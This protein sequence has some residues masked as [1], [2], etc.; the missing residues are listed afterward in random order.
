MQIPRW[1]YHILLL[2]CLLLSGCGQNKVDNTGDLP[3]IDIIGNL[4]NYEAVPVSQYITELEYVPLETNYDCFIGEEYVGVIVT[5]THIFVRGSKYCYAFGRD[6]QFLGQIGSYGQGPGEYIALYNFMVNEKT[7]SLYF[8]TL[9]TIL[10]YSLDGVFRQSINLPKDKHGSSLKRVS[11]ICDS[12]FIG[13]F[14]NY[15]GDLPHNFVLFDRSSEVVKSFDNYVHF[16]PKRERTSIVNSSME[17]YRIGERVFVKENSND[18]LFY[19]DRKNELT[20]WLVFDLGEYTNTIE[21]MENGPPIDDILQGI[22]PE[23]IVPL[24]TVTGTHN[25]IFFRVIYSGLSEKY[26]F[27]KEREIPTVAS[28]GSGLINVQS[29]GKDADNVLVIY[30]ITNQTA[31]FLDTDPV[32]YR[33][34]LINDLDGGLSFW[35]RYYTSDNE[36]VDIW[37]VE[38]MKEYLTDEYFAGH[39]IKDPASH[40][41]LKELIQKL[42]FD[43]NPVVVIAKLKPELIGESK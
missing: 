43:D 19:L 5:S 34:G 4:G 31:H 36:L 20:P 24:S 12:L 38:D 8:E 32:S 1:D 29:V 6:G 25:Y 27:P 21:K 15:K 9:R 42:D 11:F 17:P 18:T 23:L 13:H 10:E 16:K 37:R 35:P 33:K 14:N 41:K 40:Q 39:E 26:T 28:S 22:L 3:V 30:D 2:V 7:Q